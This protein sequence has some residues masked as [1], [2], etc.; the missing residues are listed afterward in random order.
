MNASTSPRF[1]RRA[2]LASSSLM[3][4]AVFALTACGGGGGTGTATGPQAAASAYAVGPITGFGSIIVNGVHYDDDLARVSDDDGV[5][6]D[7]S[8]L[9]LGMVVEVR[10][11]GADDRVAAQS[12]VT[13]SLLVLGQTVQVP[14]TTFFD[15]RL[16]GGLTAVQAG[17]IVKVY[18]VLDA[19]TGVY[20][21]TR[22]ERHDSG[23]DPFR[24][25]RPHLM[26]RARGRRTAST[27]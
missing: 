24:L 23:D 4:S 6:H 2:W 14:S 7:R 26:G 8:A 19:A 9:K 27:Q 10:G 18:G 22:I 12:I 11:Q 15:D 25:R 1:T 17:D 16:A 13:H 20:T 3:A 5:S 21:A